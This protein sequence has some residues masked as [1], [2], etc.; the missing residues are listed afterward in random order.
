MYIHEIRGNWLE[1]PFWRKS[2]KLNAQKDLNTLIK[3]GVDEVWIDTSKGLD[4]I[5]PETDQPEIPIPS[6]QEAPVETP[7]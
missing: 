7:A 1:H 4:V 3:C 5:M 6:T 2:F